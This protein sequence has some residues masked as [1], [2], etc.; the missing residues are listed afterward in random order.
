MEDSLPCSHNVD[1]PYIKRTEYSLLSI[2]DEGFCSLMNTTTNELR[3]DI[4]LPDD[5]DD[6][7]ALAK[8][9]QSDFEAG[10]AMLVSVLSA[11]KIEKIIE[12]KEA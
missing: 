6:D 8:S 7:T 5:T 10:K 11:M 4:K 1:V 2:D 9:L 3:S 12:A